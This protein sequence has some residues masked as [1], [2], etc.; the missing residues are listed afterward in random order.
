MQRGS[1][2]TV[3]GTVLHLAG[4]D[5]EIRR[6][7]GPERRP[8]Q[9]NPRDPKRPVPG[10]QDAAGPLVPKAKQGGPDRVHEQYVPTGSKTGLFSPV[11]SHPD[12][13]SPVGARA[14]PGGPPPAPGGM[15]ARPRP[16]APG[17][18][19]P[20]P[21]RPTPTVATTVRQPSGQLPPPRSAPSARA[22]PGA[23]G[24]SS[25]R[26][27]LGGVVEA[28]AWKC[29]ACG[30][31]LPKDALVKGLADVTKGVMICTDCRRAKAAKENRPAAGFRFGW[32]VAGGGCPA[33]R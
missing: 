23:P 4:K 21:A 25:T 3:E 14:R 19:N 26:I 27:S 28:G 2:D 17:P 11:G 5:E 33:L 8:A 12:R 22:L 6:M 1:G 18:A 9:P 16:A 31:G 13:H 32:T 20:A 29:A 7:S 10:K 30:K 15:L 24:A